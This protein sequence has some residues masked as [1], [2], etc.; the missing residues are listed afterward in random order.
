[1][2]LSNE[3][4]FYS[5]GEFGIRI[6]NLLYVVPV[7]ASPVGKTEEMTK[8]AAAG[9][10]TGEGKRFLGFKRLT[11]IP[12]Q[13]KLLDVRLMSNEE[14]DWLDAYHRD[15]FDRVYP[16]LTDE[17]TKE[18]LYDATSPIERNGEVSN[19]KKSAVGVDNF[20]SS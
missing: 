14:L 11:H 3:P 6:E 16:L 8:A 19:T 4:G 7:D 17:R 9:G 5:R 10:G 18:W 13:K 15:V 12:I 2:V 20:I 1:M